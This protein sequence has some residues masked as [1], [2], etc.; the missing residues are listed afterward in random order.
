MRPLGI[1]ALERIPLDHDWTVSGSGAW[2][3]GVTA[4][5]GYPGSTVFI[6]PFIF[7]VP[8]SAPA[9]A[10]IAA[11]GL[12]VLVGLT[13]FAITRARASKPGDSRGVSRRGHAC[14]NSSSG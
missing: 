11:A 5:T 12:V 8:L 7:G 3:F 6:G 4:H 1:L 9:V 14:R 2:S 10:C 13:A